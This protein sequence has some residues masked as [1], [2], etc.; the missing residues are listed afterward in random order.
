MKNSAPLSKTQ[1]GLYVECMNHQGEA[2]YN[3]P[4]LYTFDGSLDGERLAKAIEEAVKA[5]PTLFTRIEL[6]GDGEPVQTIDDAEVSG[7]KIQVSN[8]ADIEAEKAKF[9]EPFNIVG[10]RLFRLRLLKDSGH[11]YLLQDIHHIIS[12][13]A[14]RKVLLADIE[15]AYGGETLQP[16]EKTM[17]EVAMAEDAKSKSADFE[18]DKKW[19]A[20]N[21]DCGDVYSPLLGDILAEGKKVRGEAK[22][23]RQMRIEEAEVESYCQKHG[24][25]KSTFFTVAYGYL[26]AKYNNEQQALFSTIHNGRSDKQLAHSVAMLV[27]TLPV[28]AKW[29]NETTVLDFL[30]ANQEQMSG[31]RQHEAYAYSDV[32]NDLGLQAATMFAWHGTLFDSLTFA[33]QPMQAKRLNN[34]TLE[35]AIYVKGYICDG[36]YVVEAEYNP[37]EYS[38]KLVAQF[39]ES[40]EAVVAGM[41]TQTLLHDVE[42]TTAEQTALLDSFNPKGVDYDTTETVVSLFRKQA[43]ATPDAEA[44]VFKDHRYTYAQVDEISDRI[45]AYIN[46]KCPVKANNDSPLQGREN[47]VS[48]LIP[49]CEWM[50]IASMGIL[51]A[52]CAY[53]PLDPTYPKERLNFMVKDAKAKLLIADESLRDIVDEYQGPVLLTKDISQLPTANSQ[54]LIAN[55]PNPEDLFILLY[56]SGSTGVPKGCQLT[57]ANLVCYCNW[58]WK[59]YDL[60]PEHNVAEYASYGFDV[61]QEGIYPPL[62]G[63]A[64]VH[65]I[66]EELRL[67]LMALNDYF[68]REHI[69]HTFIT[70]Q[71][72]Y[73]FATN[74]ENHSLLHLSVAGEKLAPLTPPKGYKLHNGYGPTEATIIVTAFEVDQKYT[75]IPIGKPLENVR[76]YVTDSYGKRLPAGALGELWLSGPQVARG[77]LNRPDKQA[78]VFITNPFTDEAKW[79]PVYRTGDIVRYLPDGNIQF[80]GRRD[81]Q[82]KIRGF[83]IELKEVE[84]VIR[85]FPGIKDATVQAFDDEGGGKFIAAYVVSDQKVDIEVLNNFILDQKPPYMVP[86]V[87]MQI[88]AIP[89][90]Q[91]QKV[92]KRAL[93]KPVKELKVESLELRD[94]CRHPW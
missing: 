63:G 82:V 91:N 41:L 38:E 32:V 48:V 74:I 12:D 23:T 43:K 47:V 71:V 16:E 5:H 57:H 69:T 84:A 13:G 26:L 9:I 76:T 83:R 65:I 14:S 50:A 94:D 90:N 51:K 52:G 88:E 64:T 72:G 39:L 81:G 34:N 59:Y 49:R 46:E 17:A 62:T 56:T 28:Y 2:C 67:D 55:S 75:D 89:L 31:C 4:Y 79:A 86:A 20:E 87:T 18:A 70:T 29:D 30:K 10:D 60:K 19:H 36:Q 8:C 42:I 1:Y 3:I 53:Q 58:Y 11:Y 21:F 6:G 44:V 7:F 45:A 68:E 35:V 66:P 92:N 33:G 61:H 93:P 40:Y 54:Q 37:G 22:L 15:K 27:R 80:I 78:E 77:Y 24:I 73:Q 25:Y 85:E